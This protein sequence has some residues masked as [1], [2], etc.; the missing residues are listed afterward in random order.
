MYCFT[1][2]IHCVD[3]VPNI[4]PHHRN[5]CHYQLHKD[6]PRVSHDMGC[7]SMLVY[8]Q[9]NKNENK[10]I[11]QTLISNYLKQKTHKHMRLLYNKESSRRDR[12]RKVVGF[13]T[14][15]AIS[16]YHN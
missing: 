8:R 11:Q 5:H 2:T 16:A 12:D 14:T 13:S 3:F 6:V 9:R 4:Y 15:Y 1:S 10:T 7:R